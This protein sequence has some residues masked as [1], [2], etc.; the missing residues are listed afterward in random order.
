[1]SSAQRQ[2][3]RI[4]RYRNG[5]AA[6]VAEGDEDTLAELR[7]REI[8]DAL[9]AL[10]SNGVAAEGDDDGTSPADEIRAVIDEEFKADLIEARKLK[11]E[12]NEIQDAISETKK[13]IATLHR[14]S[15]DEASHHRMTDE[16]TAIVS[17]TEQATETILS[18]VEEIDSRAGDLAAALSGTQHADLAADI[19]D[20]VVKVFEACN[21]Q[22]LTGQRISKVVTAFIFIEERVSKMMEI[23][24][25]IDSFKDVQAIEIP[26]PEGDKALLN[27]PAL[28]DDENVAS[29]DDIDAL[30]D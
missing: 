27:G 22:D 11:E 23:W 15:I 16:L 4:E 14:S 13:E 26:K 12:L 3:F 21:F 9:A 5:S 25:G 10:R 18:S 28:E 17:G 7:H 6:P 30:F 29:Q 20:Q 24:G 8:M 1:M 2:V 19:Q